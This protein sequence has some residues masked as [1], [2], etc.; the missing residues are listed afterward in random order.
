MGS[1]TLLALGLSLVVLTH[2]GISR[3]ADTPAVAPEDVP[4][5]DHTAQQKRW[6][7]WQTLLV[8]AGA[9]LLFVAASSTSSEGE[10]PPFALPGLVAYVG[11]GPTVHA[12]HGRAATAVGD[13]V[14]RLGVPVLLGAVTAATSRCEPAQAPESSGDCSWMSQALPGVMTGMALA[15][16][17]DALVLSWEPR[18]SETGERTRTGAPT[19]AVGSR[20]LGAWVGVLF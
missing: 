10:P 7:G 5:G 19:I 16:V 1:R 13:L 6:Y 20:G 18:R 14:M 17:T 11:G 9:T 4:P 8:D 15:A 2:A 12:F 3:A